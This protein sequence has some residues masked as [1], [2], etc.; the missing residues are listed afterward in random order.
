MSPKLATFL[1]EHG[2]QPDNI[3][4]PQAD[5]RFAGMSEAAAQGHL[6]PQATD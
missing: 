2:F 3:N 1:V 6:M 5:G 4:A